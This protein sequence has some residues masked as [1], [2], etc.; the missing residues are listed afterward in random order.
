MRK[1]FILIVF[2]GIVAGANA[3]QFKGGLIVGTNL[4]QVDGDEVFGFKKLGFN[5][6]ACVILPLN[7]KLAISVE[8]IF[9]Q[10]G[11]FQ[12]A[13]TNYIKDTTSSAYRA[14]KLNLNYAEVPVLLQYFD[15]RNRVTFGAGLSW[16]QLVGFKEWEDKI[17]VPWGK[18]NWPYKSSDLSWVVDMNFPII[19]SWQ[20]LK[21]DF[22]YS[23]SIFSIRK[24]TYDTP[25]RDPWTR[26]QYNN[27]LTFRL[28]YIFNEPKRRILE[29]ES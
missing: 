10:K 11:S 12:N 18:N 24:R 7:D 1:F 5:T 19:K 4:T 20:K 15:K 29:D 27:V 13:D 16:G 25:Y 3:Q 28:M 22:R 21:F 14:Y 9:S 8:T 2:C 17:K 6:G 23:Y 26:K